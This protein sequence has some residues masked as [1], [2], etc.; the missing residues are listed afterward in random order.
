ME[1]ADRILK[2]VECGAEFVF[3]SGEQAFFHEKQ[4]TNDPKRC[5]ECR[6]HQGARRPRFRAETHVICSECGAETTVPFKPT[7]GKPVL[8]RPCFQKSRGATEKPASADTEQPSHISPGSMKAA[9]PFP[10]ASK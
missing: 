1:F 7:Q 3:S 9:I 8:C 5:R 10:Q 2:C 4:F 6:I